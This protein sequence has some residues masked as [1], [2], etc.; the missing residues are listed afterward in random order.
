V[1]PSA[2]KP[3][4]DTEYKKHYRTEAL[5]SKFRVYTVVRNF[6]V[7][8][9]RAFEG[10]SAEEANE[11]AD[12]FTDKLVNAEVEGLQNLDQSAKD[13]LLK[14]PGFVL[15]RCWSSIGKHEVCHREF[16]GLLNQGIRS[17]NENVIKEAVK[18]AATMNS[19][20]VMERNTGAKEPP[21]PKE[22]KAENG[23]HAWQL[24]R[25][26]LLPDDK[27]AWYQE[28]QDKDYRVNMFLR[29]STSK[30]VAEDFM[31]AQKNA[32]CVLYH[33]YLDPDLRCL[34]VNCLESVKSVQTEQEFLFPPYSAFRVLKIVEHASFIEIDI[35]VH[36]DNR[37]VDED[38]P[39]AP[40]A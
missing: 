39:T 17:D 5:P 30:T 29:T 36:P 37:S 26:G 2:P 24:W 6:L 4:K 13:E 16:C 23:Q 3:F 8:F 20:C 25:G 11:L 15:A 21:W 12:D 38:V 18:L 35:K 27:L 31:R 32:K 7:V 40:W 28:H 9:Y 10:K 22:D 33:F 19:F 34:H 14:K 1:A